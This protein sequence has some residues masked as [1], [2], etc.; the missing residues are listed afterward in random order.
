MAK[1]TVTRDQAVAVLTAC[2]LIVASKWDDDKLQDKMRQLD[3]MDGAEDMID[4]ADDDEVR[5]I[6][7]RAI[8]ACKQK[9]PIF[10]TGA[11]SA[12]QESE[13]MEGTSDTPKV[14]GKKPVKPVKPVKPA[15]K[16]A[17]PEKKA[18]KER[19]PVEKDEWGARVGTR[20]S[21]INLALIGGKPLSA[22]EIEAAADAHGIHSHLSKLK[23]EGKIGM[24]PDGKYQA[25]GAVAKAKKAKK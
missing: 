18:K 9:V 17:E 13:E 6:G 11:A 22:K 23:A 19:T 4:G 8:H 25:K 12:T 2:R 14:K 16:K 24:T 7:K 10:V 21:R 20:T 15:A 3:K 5:R 1:M